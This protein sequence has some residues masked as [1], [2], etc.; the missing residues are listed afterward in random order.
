MRLV[1]VC[2]AG[3]AFVSLGLPDGLLGVAWP[4]IRRFFALDVD[5]LGALLVAGT[6][7]YVVSSFSSGRLLSLLNLAAVLALSCAC[8]A[9]ALLGYASLDSWTALVALAVLLGFGGGAIDAALNTYVA[10]RYG[11]RTLNWLHA[12]YGVGA[13]GGPVIMTAVLSRGLP[14]QRGYL[15]VGAAQLVLAAAFL[16]TRRHWPS[17]GGQPAHGVSGAGETIA[18]T[19]RIPGAQLG[20]LTFLVYAGVEASFGA[21]TYTLLTAGRGLGTVEAGVLVTA[22]WASLTIGRLLMAFGGD[23]LPTARLLRIAIGGVALG[24]AFVWSNAG[25]L[26]TWTGVVLA[27]VACGPIFPTL[28]AVTPARLGSGHAANAVGFQ[29][30]A[31]SLGLSFVPA[32][33][34]VMADRWGIEHIS[35]ALLGLGLLLGAAYGVLDRLAPAAAQVEGGSAAGR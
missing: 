28:V 29:I 15:L 1:R 11:P 7:G 20:I 21:W 33:V 22:F 31:A 19:L 2:L 27:G 8:T 5:A 32:L 34:G 9:A 24:A 4:S 13:A 16:A 14:W 23:L 30:A 10:T 35:T 6:A 18:A 17:V 12:C 3:L 25:L 26:T